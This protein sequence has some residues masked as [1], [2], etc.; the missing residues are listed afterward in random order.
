MN[1]VVVGGVAGGASAAARSRRLSE[2]AAN[3]VM[4]TQYSAYKLCGRSGS[5]C[6]KGGNG[7]GVAARERH[8]G[9]DR[10]IRSAKAPGRQC[11]KSEG[12]G[13]QIVPFV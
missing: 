11:A 4:R 10:L 9:R 6:W 3:V 12:I 5:R 1:I 7:D 8:L 2:D 13:R